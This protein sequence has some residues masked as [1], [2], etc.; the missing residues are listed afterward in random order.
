MA[1][2]THLLTTEETADQLNLSRAYFARDRWLSKKN[3]VPPVV[4]FVRIGRAVR[5][6]QGDLDRLIEQGAT[7]GRIS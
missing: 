1:D 6:R 4:P 7:G 3:G 5:Y 2:H